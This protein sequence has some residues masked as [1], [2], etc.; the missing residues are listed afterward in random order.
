VMLGS[1]GAHMI[2]MALPLA[3][4]KFVC[5]L[6]GSELLRYGDR[7]RRLLCRAQCVIVP[8]NFTG[9]LVPPG[10]KTVVAWP[11]PCAAALQPVPDCKPHS[12]IRILTLARLHPRKGQVDVA[13]A[14]ALL[15]AADRQ[16]VTYQ[17]GGTGQRAYLRAVE[18]T[19]RAAGVAFEYLGP[20]PPA[21][22]A[23][24]YAQC[25]IFVMTSRSLRRSIEGF[26]IAFLEAGY[27]GKPVIGY[28]SGGAAEAVVTGETGWLVAEG[29]VPTVA[30]TLAQLIA[31][32]ALRQKIGEQGR[33][34]ARQFTWDRTAGIIAAAID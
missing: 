31:D 21:Q 13:R 7:L 22:L 18:R 27:H 26:G 23:A 14:L 34:H 4:G 3:T 10:I 1:R 9:S 32:P 16:V 25:D 33:A 28:R 6:H 2:F 5:L 11:A 20:I 29:D 19:C 8:S 12:G 15:P 30:A 17:V 24:T